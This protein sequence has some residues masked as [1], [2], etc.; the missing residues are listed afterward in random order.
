MLGILEACKFADVAMP[1]YGQNFGE[2]MKYYQQ[3]AGEDSS[4]HN[5]LLKLEYNLAIYGNTSILI[6]QLDNALNIK[7]TNDYPIL[8]DIISLK[9]PNTYALLTKNLFHSF[10]DGSLGEM[11]DAISSLGVN[12]NCLLSKAA[13]FCACENEK[14]FFIVCF[15]LIN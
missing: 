6:S 5:L 10:T 2:Y 1:Y 12:G 13:K 15:Y 8:R 4:S 14:L 7:K 11:K 9:E 3:I